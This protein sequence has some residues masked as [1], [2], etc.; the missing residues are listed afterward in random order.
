[1][2]FHI[3]G[4]L[5]NTL[6]RVAEPDR[7]ARLLARGDFGV[8]LFFVI[9]G[10]VI[11]LPFAKA[12]L[13]GDRLPR[14]RDYFFRR[15]TRLEP[16]YIV[17]LLVMFGFLWIAGHGS[18]TALIP[19]LFASV[20]YVHNVIYAAMSTINVVA[21]SLEIEFQFYALAPLIA[22]LFLISRKSWRRIILSAG[23]ASFALLTLVFADG[24]PRFNLSILP[25][26]QFFLTGFLLCDIYLTDWRSAPQPLSLRWDAISIAAWIGL[27]ALLLKGPAGV[28]FSSAVVLVAYCAAFKGTWSNRFLRHP[29]V[30]TIGG[31]CYTIYLYHLQVDA[32][33]GI[34][35]PHITLLR[36]APLWLAITI[37]CV[38]EVPVML[39][40]SAAFFILIEKPCMKKNWYRPLVAR[41]K[42]SRPMLPSD[43][44][45]APA[46]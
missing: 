16:P 18:F 37:A 34:F 45:A 10:F 9:S 5:R 13:F 11:A 17:N 41:L 22:T 20:F 28:F 26:A 40:V 31:M 36:T 35:Q 4:S 39:A 25:H 3:S 2:L 14:L 32:V 42:R 12:H 1:M 33:F 7:L 19:H 21:W 6:H 15:L 44:V 29:L 27:A 23:I 24:S 38:V 46:E 8:K 43:S 30:Y